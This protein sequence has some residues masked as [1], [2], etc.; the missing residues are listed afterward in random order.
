MAM[1]AITVRQWWWLILGCAVL[2]RL[3]V[4]L[5]P[6]VNIDENEYAFAAR[7]LLAGGLPYRDFLIYQPPVIYYLYAFA[8]WAFGTTQLWAPHLLVMGIVCATTAVLRS[9]GDLVYGRS[10]GLWTAACY[11]VFSTT[12]LPMDMLGANCEVVLMLPL[13]GAL[14]W[15]VRASGS[16]RARAGRAVLAGACCGIAVLTKYPAAV[17]LPPLA[18]YLAWRETGW[19]RRALLGGSVV[20][21][22]LGVVGVAAAALAAAGVWSETVAA[23]SYIFRYAKGPPQSDAAYVALKFVV[24]TAM[25]ALAA[26][27]LWWAALCAAIARP[28]ADPI[29]RLFL[30]CLVAGCAAVL[31]GGR[32][33]FHYYYFLLPPLCLL[34]GA[35]LGGAFGKGWTAWPRGARAAWAAWT[36]ACVAMAIGLSVTRYL[37]R[38]NLTPAE[39]RPVAEYLAAAAPPGATLFVWG[40]CPQLYTVSGLFPATR[41][42]TADYLTGRTPKT[43]GLE[44]D[45]RGMRIPSAW[46]KVWADFRDPSAVV[47]EDTA[48]NIFPRAW[49]YLLADFSRRLP[50][51]I[52]DTA[53]ANYRRYGRYPLTQ[54]PALHSL[55]AREYT[56]RARINNYDCYFRRSSVADLPAARRAAGAARRG[57]PAD[58]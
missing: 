7:I 8:S 28:A 16:L 47:M 24:R 23:A 10:A 33:Y 30:A 42:S 38:G 48:E 43:A 37:Q 3:P 45:P 15:C 54:F 11:A 14:W 41:F 46:E 19:R 36:A 1:N 22:A 25:I 21:G 4:F 13:A 53:P 35:S 56:K 52:V 27:L 17:F 5:F 18:G 40:Y 51:V 44:Y 32:I 20:A 6:Y 57:D 34:A 58:L 50:D 39:W 2:L 9:I 29:R 31:A 12:F 55:I 49:D 26:A